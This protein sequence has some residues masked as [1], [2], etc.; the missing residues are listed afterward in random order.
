MYDCP[1]SMAE[2]ERLLIMRNEECILG[3][4]IGG[5]NC[6]MGLV[7]RELEVTDV[8]VCPSKK[9]WMAEDAIEALAGVIR[10][11]IDGHP[12]VTVTA[13]SMGFPSLVDRT[14]TRLLSSTN[15]PGLDGV[16]IVEELERR[17]GRKVYIEHDAYYLLAYDIADNG[18]KN[19]GTMVGMY[20]GTGLGNALFINGQ[21]YIGKNGAACEIGHMPIPFNTYQCSCGK[22]GC[23]EMFSCGK[24]LERMNRECYPDT[25]IGDMFA[26][27][28]KEKNMCD[29]VEYMAAAVATEVNILDP[30]YVFLGGGIIQMQGFPKEHLTERIMAHVRKPY[31]ASGLQ[32]VFQRPGAENGIV[33]AAIR[34]FEMEEKREDK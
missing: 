30:D 28:G 7:N 14:R 24:A 15:F 8:T 10:E 13:L 16:N 19:T 4:D 27:H 12:K 23:I 21:P 9:I 32:I 2:K 34:A 26:R 18:L 1:I 11:Y 17:L 5:T 20:F 31:P 33:G 3:M 29:F 25:P 22:E 6:R